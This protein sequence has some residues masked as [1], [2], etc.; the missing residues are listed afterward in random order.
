MEA[1]QW[2]H[3]HFQRTYRLGYLPRPIS[4][5]LRLLCPGL[6]WLVEKAPEFIFHICLALLQVLLLE[7]KGR[8]DEAVNTLA[9]GP[10]AHTAV[11]AEGPSSQFSTDPQ[12]RVGKAMKTHT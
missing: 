4:R 10:P 11:M 1:G 2:W 3:M 7:A 8:E 5:F 6:T 12:H 9:K